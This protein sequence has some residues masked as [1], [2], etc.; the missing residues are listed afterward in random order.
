LYEPAQE[1]GRF[2]RERRRQGCRRRAY[3]DVFTAI[4]AKLELS[5]I[6][7][8]IFLP[9]SNRSY[10]LIDQLFFEFFDFRIVQIQSRRFFR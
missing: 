1:V 8:A 4:L 10:A 7:S 6:E 2:L 3:M 5:S 9:I